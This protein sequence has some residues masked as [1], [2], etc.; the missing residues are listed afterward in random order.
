MYAVTTVSSFS[1][2]KSILP[3]APNTGTTGE[4]PPEFKFDAPKSCPC[5]LLSERSSAF[6]AYLLLLSKIWVTSWNFERTACDVP[7]ISALSFQSMA[8][9][10]MS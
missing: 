9:G 10:Q 3:P 2:C 5:D 1:I 8:T 4:I 7:F 6:Q